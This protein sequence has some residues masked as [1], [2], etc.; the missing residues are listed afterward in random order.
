MKKILSLILAVITIIS[1]LCIGFSAYAAG[2]T[3]NAKGLN[4]GMTY[5][6][7]A[8]ATDPMLYAE[9]TYYY[10]AYY[11]NLSSNSTITL[12]VNAA[13]EDYLYCTIPRIEIYK[14]TN[15]ANPVCEICYFEN[16]KFNSGTGKYEGSQ[17]INLN[18]GK[19]YIVFKY[20][21]Y[22]VT[23]PRLTGSFNFKIS[24]SS[25][26]NNSSSSTASSKPKIT[27]PGNPKITKLKKGKKSF[28]VQW[29]RSSNTT[30][31]QIQYSLKKNFSGAKNKWS[32][33]SKL[34]VKKLKSKKT[35]Y[36]RVRAYKK[37]NGKNYYSAWSTKKIKVK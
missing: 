21:D 31:Y 30:G 11:F 19:Y 28:T 6:E 5:T 26:S 29:S 3:S 33:G 4:L 24:V 7:R 10:D 2:F 18:S 16:E 37:I 13:D 20:V 1:T 35:Y 25:A 9:N 14:S 17:K 34:T 32:T 12:S 27:Y 36:V 15:T 23:D 8:S 22:E